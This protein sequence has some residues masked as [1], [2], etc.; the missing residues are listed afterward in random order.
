MSEIDS[1]C[2]L[3]PPILTLIKHTALDSY[4]NVG[5]SMKVID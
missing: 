4:Q 2:Y 5:F 3:N 1:Y